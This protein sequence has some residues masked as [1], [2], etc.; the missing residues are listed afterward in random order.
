MTSGEAGLRRSALL[1]IARG[2]GIVFVG[3]LV[4][5][6]LKYGFHFI[7]A[8]YLGAERFGLFVLGLT[9]FT[10]AEIIAH[11][12]LLQGVIRYVSMYHGQRDAGRIKGIILLSARVV[13]VSGTVVGLG[14]FLASGLLSI[15]VFARPELAP[16][17]R[18]FAVMTPFSVLATILLAV[19]QGFKVLEYKIYVAEFAE[20]LLRIAGAVAAISVLG[21]VLSGVL[22]SYGLAAIL[23][24]LLALILLGK[25]FP[26]MKRKDVR[27]VFESRRLFSFSW[28]LL[29]SALLGQLLLV[30]D[31]FIL[32]ILGTSENVGIYG[33]AQRT[34]LLANMIFMSFNAIFAP[35]IADYYQRKEGRDL[36]RLFKIVAKWSFAL[37]LP[38]SL[39]LIL[40]AKPVLILF[41]ERFAQGAGA[42][43]VL[44]GGWLFHS[45]LG[46]AGAVLTMSGRSRWHLANFSLFLAL[47]ISLNLILIPRFGIIGAAAG[48]ALSLALID[49][50]TCVQVYLML[51]HHPFRLDELKP[52]LAGGVALL[53]TK[54]LAARAFPDDRVFISIP[55]LGSAFVLA[56]AAIIFILGISEEEKMVLGQAWQKLRRAG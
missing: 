31:T 45:A 4:G 29:F 33:A 47:Q 18:V 49:I 43:A 44:A 51:G 30:S 42:L 41:G 10:V 12:G 37:T 38:A 27:P 52:L 55:V 28:P 8:R 24:L 26:D 22:W 32:G 34:G 19:F 50:I 17:L 20:P 46:H 25:V 6:G 9:V 7:I 35:I 2:A 53:L 54:L 5:S 21:R 36:N 40:L 23:S 11:L 13:A 3:T 14:L 39:L 16:V 1:S 56:Y 15:R 48:T